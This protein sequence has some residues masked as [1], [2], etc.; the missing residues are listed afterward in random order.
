MGTKGTK[1]NRVAIVSAE[2]PTKKLNT[3]EGLTKKKMFGRH[4]AFHEGKIFG[5]LDS[6]G[7]YSFK[8]NETNKTDFEQKESVK[9]SRI[10]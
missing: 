5:V 4:G 9:H 10:V 1:L 8:G 2:L 6:K 3:I 7:D